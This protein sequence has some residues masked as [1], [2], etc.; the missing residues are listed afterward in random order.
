ML[1]LALWIVSL[2][3][4][5]LSA[6]SDAG[7]VSV[8]PAT[9]WASFILLVVAFLL[10]VTATRRSLLLLLA[11]IALELVFLYGTP[12]VVEDGPRTQ[13]A[14]K[15]AGIV[16]YIMRHGTVDGGVDAFFNWPGFF[17]LQAF[18]VKI[19]GLSS[20]LTLAKWAP[21]VF[22]LAYLFPLAVIFRALG[23]NRRHVWIALW[24]FVS[25][26]WVGQDYLSPQA[27]GYFFYL[28]IIATLVV[29]VAPLEKSLRFTL[30]R[31]ARWTRAGA[32]VL[33]ILTF[34]ATVPS[35]Q[36]T[37]WM[38]VLAVGSLG[39]VRRGPTV[40]LAVL[41]AVLAAAWVTYFTGPFLAG[42]FGQVAGPVGSVGK[43]L[44]ANTGGRFQ[45]SSE[46]LAVLRLREAFS[47]GIW[48]AAATGIVLMRRAGRRVLVPAV[49]GLAPFLAI[50]LAQYGGELGL[51]TFFF[52]L[53]PASLGAAAILTIILP[54]WKRLGPV[55][56]TGALVACG[57]AFVITR[58]GNE[59]QDAFTSQDIAA[60]RYLYAHA[61]PRADVFAAYDNLPWRYL[62]Y[63][64]YRYSILTGDLVR[65]ADIHGIAKQMRN[66]RLP[67]AYLVL[68]R[69]EQAG[70][71][72]FQGWPVT[73]IPRLRERL[74]KSPRFQL[75][76]A[77][78]TAAIFK[79]RNGAAIAAE[80]PNAH[81]R[82]AASAPRTLGV[83]SE[84]IITTPDPHASFRS[85]SSHPW[86]LKRRGSRRCPNDSV[87]I[88]EE[89]GM[90]PTLLPSE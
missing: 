4:I 14:W 30:L 27:F 85:I 72:I 62:H 76:F 57:V 17:I 13:T 52:T 83:Y 71:Q 60:V 36:L 64:D 45:G 61:K 7:L 74:L 53:P 5:R 12:S 28:T 35:H 88:A 81:R 48:L 90:P 42:H 69:S 32:L 46:H 15:L 73:V 80:N 47:V 65:A 11:I 39:V 24:L 20:S 49:L 23:L 31:D 55:L 87:V 10:A 63:A 41:M 66:P 16:D 9:F 70:A 26:N 86:R 82:V 43:N 1:S 77:N 22:N 58:Y 3:Q 18:L 78:E 34:A 67:N 51:R 37:P 68:T 40:G 84:P 89:A 38:A 19:A 29:A 59:R 56:V 50:G 54:R 25:A 79:L 21:L 33:T 2:W 75:L 6:M 8:L 44:F